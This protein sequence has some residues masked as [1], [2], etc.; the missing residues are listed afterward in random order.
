MCLYLAQLQKHCTEV[1][2]ATLRNARPGREAA[3]VWEKHRQEVVEGKVGPPMTLDELD[4]SQVL[5]AERFGLEGWWSGAAKVRVIDNFRKNWVNDHSSLWE[6]IWNDTQD[7]LTAAVHG[8]QG[9]GRIPRQV[10]IG[11]ED[12]VSA[13]KTV[14]PAAEHH[15]LMWALVFDTDIGEWKASEPGTQPFGALGGVYAWWRC[16]QAIRSII[17]RLFW[18]VLFFYVDDV[19]MAE[20]GQSARRAK[21]IF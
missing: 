7:D 13:Y 11:K 3:K 4:F 17:V 1:N 6:R 5:L 8:L 16:G 10:L 9:D 18:L 15:W 12:F 14:C 20:L 21:S 19:F 2:L